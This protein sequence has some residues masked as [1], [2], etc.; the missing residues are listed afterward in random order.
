MENNIYKEVNGKIIFNFTGAARH[1]DEEF[2]AYKQRQR[3]EK[4]LEKI[5]KHPNNNV[6]HDSFKYGS[7]VNVNK[8]KK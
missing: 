3:L 1:P 8:E 5:R 7:Y 4:E 6:F 2:S